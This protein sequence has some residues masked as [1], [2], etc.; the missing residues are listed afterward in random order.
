MRKA[1]TLA[2]AALT[3]SPFALTAAAAGDVNE[4]AKQYSYTHKSGE[5]PTESR[6]EEAKTEAGK[7]TA[8]KTKPVGPEPLYFGF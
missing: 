7:P 5:C 6:T 2:F 8:Q 1:M 4:K 3:A